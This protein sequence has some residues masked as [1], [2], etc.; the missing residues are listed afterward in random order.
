MARPR[1]YVV[2]VG[3]DVPRAVEL[4]YDGR[5][6]SW[7]AEVEGRA[8][9]VRLDEVDDDGIVRVTVDGR[10]IELRM[11]QTE[12]GHVRLVPIQS[13]GGAEVPVRVRSA[14]RVV[15]NT[16]AGA[17]AHEPEPKVVASI[18]GVVLDVRVAVGAK[19]AASDEL[20]VLEA[21]K[22]ET[23]LR[24]P[25]SG[26]VAAIHVEAGTKVRTGDVLVEITVPEDDDG[27]NGARLH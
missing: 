26:V 14:G 22:M 19:V 23:V 16:A 18:T 5:G 27:S 10:Q 6:D 21:M 15:M 13:P 12:D 1:R 25:R 3:A 2:T 4:K 9:D 11:M 8:F 7:S 17:S 24:S 20:I